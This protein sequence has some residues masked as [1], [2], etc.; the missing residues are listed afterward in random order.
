[1]LIFAIFVIQ[2]RPQ[3][4][5]SPWPITLLLTSNLCICPCWCR[6]KTIGFQHVTESPSTLSQAQDWLCFNGFPFAFSP[7][8][9]NLHW[10]VLGLIFTH[11]LGH[12]F[13]P[14]S[15]FVRQHSEVLFGLIL[16]PCF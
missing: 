13:K 4:D 14:P 1:M 11:E 5:S 9:S 12:L 2:D 7:L 6:D 3:A 8:A 16:A 15:A 10:N